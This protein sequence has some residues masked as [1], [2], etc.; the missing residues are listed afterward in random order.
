MIISKGRE[1]NGEPKNVILVSVQKS[2][3]AVQTFKEP[4]FMQCRVGPTVQICWNSGLP[5]AMVMCLHQCNVY[6]K[7]KLRERRG[8]KCNPWFRSKSPLR[9]TGLQII[10]FHAASYRADS[11]NFQEFGATFRH[12]TMF[13]P[14]QCLYQKEAKGMQSPKM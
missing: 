1:E 8:K 14:M 2:H 9:S 5:F 13:E 4:G 12:G 7:R 10:R 6:I 3:F 11:T